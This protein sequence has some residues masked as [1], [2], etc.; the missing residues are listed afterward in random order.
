M[1]HW[2]WG[3]RKL[4][5]GWLVLMPLPARLMGQ[6]ESP[7]TDDDREHWSFQ[8]IVEYP[9]P[10]VQHATWPRSP[11]DHF[12]LSGIEQAELAPA[13]PADAAS[14]LRRLK[15]D[16]LGLPPTPEEVQQFVEQYAHDEDAYPQWVDRY[17]NSP[18]FGESQAQPWLDL[19]RF[20]E[21]DGFEFDKLREGAWEYR[22]WIVDALN[23]DVPYDQFVA[24][25][26]HGDLSGGADDRVATMFCLAGP[27]MPDINEQDLR[28]HDR[29]NELTSTVGAALLGLQMHCAQCHDHKYDPISQAD[30]Y[31]LRAIFESSVPALRRDQ[32]FVRFD[33]SRSDILPRLFYRGDLLSPGPELQPAFPRIAQPAQAPT[34]CDPH[35]PRQSFSRWLFAEHNPLTARVIANRVWQWHFGRS[36]CENPSDFGVVA[37]GPSH[38]ELLD[39][40][41]SYLRRQ[42]W[43]LKRLHREIVLSATYRQ[44]SRPPSGDPQWQRRVEHDP[45][46]E[47]YSRYPRRRL[48]GEKLRDAMLSVAGLLDNQMRGASVMP[49]LPTELTGT[50]LKGQWQTSRSEADHYR[51]S[52]YIFARRNLRYPL[53]D[54]FDRPDAGASCPQRSQT[55]TAMQALQMLNSELSAR[56]ATALAEDL[57]RHIDASSPHAASEWIDALFQRALARS[58]SD[59][60]IQWLTGHV[61]DARGRAAVALAVLN[62]NEF[63]VVD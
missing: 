53:F 33:A 52:I 18:Q 16:L 31:R 28:R 2:Q 4:L 41:A 3:L 23:R 5:L 59:E 60:D 19:A 10:V 30:F 62:C 55:T 44:A 36:L 50:L 21:T 11:I 26:L 22:D 6:H 1:S 56:C 13:P 46:N 34:A 39:W 61:G 32:P 20:A 15:F 49:P 27:D 37:G 9:L 43:S 12:I 17:L 51:R 47:L 8:P 25:Q 54:L 14:L 35:Q 38:P 7:L 58:A 40:L 24:L 57:E 42:Q 29:L 45:H 48:E 63:L